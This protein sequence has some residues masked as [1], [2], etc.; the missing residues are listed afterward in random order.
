MNIANRGALVLRYV[1][2]NANIPEHISRD[3]ELDAVIADL[4]YRGQV[5]GALLTEGTAGNTS[6]DSI[7]TVR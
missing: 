6:D 2:A 7:V 1:S 3:E 4:S 5:Y